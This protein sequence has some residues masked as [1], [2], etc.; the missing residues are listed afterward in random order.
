MKCLPGLVLCAVLLQGNLRRA[1]RQSQTNSSTVHTR[2]TGRH[3]HIG[4]SFLTRIRVPSTTPSCWYFTAPENVE[5]TTTFR[6]RTRGWPPAGRIPQ[7][8][9]KHPCFVRGAPVPAQW[10]LEHRRSHIPY[11]ARAC[12]GERYSG[13]TCQGILHRHKSDLRYRLLDGWKRNVGVSLCGFP[14]VSLPLS[15]WPGA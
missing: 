6:L 4:C 5:Q 12:N 1:T 9:C 11:S 3:C 8:S 15:R 14:S 7:L 2:T 10:R 13:F